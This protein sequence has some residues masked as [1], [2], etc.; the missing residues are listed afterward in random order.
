MNR[1]ASPYRRTLLVV[2]ACCTVLCAAVPVRAQQ[3][4]NADDEAKTNQSMFRP[5]EDWPDPT[6]YRSASGAPGP[7]YW[8]Q[9]VDY[10]IETALDTTAHVVSGS[11]HVTYHNNSPHTLSYVWI[12]LDQN[13]RSIEHSR[14][15]A[16]EEALPDHVSPAFAEYVGIDKFDGGFELSRVQVKDASGRMVDARHLVNNTLMK[17]HLAELIGTGETA[18]I[19]I[20][21]SFR[22][23]DQARGAKERVR[24]GWLYSVAQWYPR[25]AVFD[26]VNGWQTDQFMGQGEFYLEYG[27]FDVALTLPEGWLDDTDGSGCALRED[28]SEMSGG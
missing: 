24:D 21:W 10:R 25:L 19:G 4:L 5:L 16:A 8:Q 17:V 6:D 27:D 2:A 12:Q 14:T 18:E 13:R 28:S 3:W 22:V 15:Y 7:R 1:T 11:E 23:P 9:Q 26:D 20:D